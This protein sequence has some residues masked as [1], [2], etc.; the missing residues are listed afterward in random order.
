MEYFRFVK[1]KKIEFCRLLVSAVSL[2][3]VTGIIQINAQLPERNRLINLNGEWELYFG[4]QDD[5]AP[6]T[7][8]ELSSS[9]FKKIKAIV[10]G[11]VE[12]DLMREGILP[13]ISKGTNVFKLREYE[14]YQWW[15]IKKF[16]LDK[17]TEPQ[18]INMV[19]NGLDCVSDIFINGNKAA[20]TDN[21]FITHKLDVSN[22]LKPGDNVIHV[23][24]LSSVIEGRNQEIT[25]FERAQGGSRWESLN[26][27]KAPHMY[28]W[29]IMPRIV[30]AG[31]WR[32]VYLEK[33]EE[34]EFRSVYWVTSSVD[35]EKKLANLL[36]RWDFNT[37]ISVL[38]GMR[39]HVILSDPDGIQTKQEIPVIS[40]HG[41][42]NL[43]LKDVE[44]WWPRG[45]GKQPLYIAELILKD[46]E[47][48]V[49]CF[50]RDKIGIRTINLDR[51]NITTPENPGRFQFVVN[52][53]PVF[54][55]GT[56]WVPLD[57]LHSRDNQHLDKMFEMLV[58]LNCN[59]VRCWGGNVY[60]DTQFYDLCDRNGIMVWQD[61][62]MA[63][64]RYPQDNIFLNKIGTEAVSVIKK[65]RNHPSLAL[66]A[67]NNENDE[68]YT[69]NLDNG[70][71]PSDPNADDK[72]SRVIL[73]EAVRNNDP[74]R[75]YLPSSPYYSPEVMKAG[76][77]N[78][79]MPEVHLWGPRGYYKA[80]FYIETNANFVSEI[81]YHGCPDLATIRQMMDP[82]YV[83]PD[84]KNR[85][86]NDQWLAKAT[87]PMPKEL[88]N[89]QLK[90]NDLMVNQVEA[91]FGICPDSFEDFIFASQATQAE[92]KKFFIDF[93][94]SHKPDKMGIL[95]W[96]LRDGWPI[97]S[98]A[99]V[100]Y[101]FR[102]KI[103][104][105][106]IKSAQH[107]IQAIVCEPAGLLHDVVLVNDTRKEE[108]GEIM[109]K[110]IHTGK[111]IFRAV[112]NCPGNGRINV[113]K[114]SASE[115]QD[116]WII[117]WSASGRNKLRSHY[118]NGKVPFNLAEYK[119]WFGEAGY[120]FE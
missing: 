37:D 107:D 79:T 33:I 106:Y 51:T 119:K 115:K 72:I 47:G 78:N 109:I 91:L 62:S 43:R 24:I 96:N 100:D 42:L 8:M 4:M 112:Y 85:K 86:W 61:F 118:L 15:Y 95:W 98:D 27:R 11:N 76:F 18:H 16:Y 28:G 21:M 103:A 25:M 87:M 120:T 2:I 80:P 59:M 38:D 111:E 73:K 58:D 23:R 29:D 99:I 105:E 55:K 83:V 89:S 114:I 40:N 6:T 74:F 57:G 102:K 69:K 104:Y 116:M 10:P 52:G 81:G 46:S 88:T 65:F 70:M 36:I 93:W 30:S 35:L 7:P 20:H 77:N 26:I 92:A 12:I 94:R 9:K 48:K 90:R 13:D 68:E 60:E 56:N 39:M 22:L 3:L 108:Q 110:S 19:F 34:T 5:D 67:G 63:C 53:V 32:D 44:F 71:P 49:I 75:D 45:Y 117:E 66:W 101:Y 1:T 14:T 97:L 41:S 54:V 113:G 17:F 64:A 82:E 84:F 31:I 50:S